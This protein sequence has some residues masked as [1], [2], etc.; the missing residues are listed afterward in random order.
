MFMSDLSD[1]SNLGDLTFLGHLSNLILSDL[2]NLSAILVILWYLQVFVIDTIIQLYICLK[3][4]RPY[5]KAVATDTPV[6]LE[7]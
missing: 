5:P 4:L 7:I 3:L 2:S 1:L 6:D